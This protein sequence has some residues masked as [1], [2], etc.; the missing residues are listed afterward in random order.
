MHAMEQRKA[1]PA[2]CC[3]P[4]GA[5][6]TLSP[7]FCSENKNPFSIILA[8]H[9]NKMMVSA[10]FFSVPLFLPVQGGTEPVFRR[11]CTLAIEKQAV[12]TAVTH[13]ALGL[14]RLRFAIPCSGLFTVND[15]V[16]GRLET[17][18]NSPPTK[19]Q[20]CWPAASFGR[21]LPPNSC[22][23]S[24]GTKSP[25]SQLL[26]HTA[27]TVLP[28]MPLWQLFSVGVQC[29]SFS[30][31]NII[32]YWPLGPQPATGAWPLSCLDL[33]PQVVSLLSEIQMKQCFACNEGAYF[34]S[35]KF[36]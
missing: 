23:S 4:L 2:P 13:T 35:F 30:R 5:G 28:L 31:S 14:A 15:T 26:S 32:R 33:N 20:E 10:A 29:H 24:K 18:G 21:V 17:P 1:F 8:K 9:T 6:R 34:E 27:S 7:R 16:R 25:A 12:I 19:P 36:S 3:W 11:N 22:F